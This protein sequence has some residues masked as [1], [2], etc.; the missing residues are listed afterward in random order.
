MLWDDHID[1]VALK[2]SR[3]IGFITRSKN[4][5]PQKVKL[6]L[7]HALFRSH[8]NYCSLVWGT[9]TQTGLKK[10]RTLEKR[11]LRLVHNLP[12][13]H[14]TKNLFFKNKII[15]VFSLYAYRL[16]RTYKLEQRRCISNISDLAPIELF[17]CTYP[18]RHKPHWV[19]PKVR[20]NY[21]R[22]MVAFQ[23]PSLLNKLIDENIDLGSISCSNLRNYFLMNASL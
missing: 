11:A 4:Y 12:S 14:S 23:L 22:Q 8:L 20:T 19:L 9:A 10:L 17:H 5:L 16:L 6:S 13:R 1:D 3:A 2:A 15:N 21:G 18:R 7:Y